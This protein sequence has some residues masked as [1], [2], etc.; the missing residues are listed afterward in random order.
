[1]S[2]PNGGARKRLPQQPS[3]E[4][5]R[6]QAKRR[7]RLDAIQLAEAQHRLAVEYG[8]ASWPKLMAFV[9]AQKTR[10]ADWY[11]DPNDNLPKAANGGDV[12]KVKALLES[13]RFTQA[14]LDTALG[15]VVCGMGN[16]SNTDRWVLA[17]LLIDAG[18]DPD[19]DYG[20]NYGPIIFGPCEGTS[21]EG[22]QYL[23]DKGA[24][25]GF[26][27]IDTKYGKKAP[28][29]HLLG[30]YSRGKN[31]AKHKAIELLLSKGAVIPPEVTPEVFAVHRGDAKL[32]G[33]MIDKDRSLIR[34]TFRDMPYGNIALAGATLLHCAVEFGEI[35]CIDAILSRY[36]NWG[37]LDMNFKAEVIDGIGGQTPIYHAINTNGDRCF[38]VLEYLVQRVGQYID[39]GVKATWRSY[40]QP[41]TEPLTPLE[42]ALKA[43]REMDPKWAHYKPRVKDEIAL[44]VPLDRRA[45]I[46]KA[47]EVGDIDTVRKMLD[48][49]S[50]LLTGELWPGVIMKAR[51]VELVRLLLDRGLSPNDC[52]APRKPLH[53]AA[54][55]M[56][57][58]IIELLVA[59]GA[60]VNF[61][62][63]LG[64][65]PMD[66]IDAYEPR[67]IGD[68]QS[69]RSRNALVKGG[70]KYDIHAAIRM[71][72]MA[73]VKQMLDTDPKAVDV[74]ED[75]W[76]PLAWAARMARIEFVQLLLDRGAVVDGT[77]PQ[78]NT[79]LWFACQSGRDAADRLAVAKL[80]IDHGADVNKRCEEGSMPI[81]YAAWRG[82]KAMVTLLLDHGARHWIADDNG[83]TPADYCRENGVAADKDA[84]LEVLT[85]FRTDDIPFRDAIAAIDAGDVPKLKHLLA[86]HPRLVTDR[87][88]SDS[89]LTRGYFA[90]PALLWFVAE[91]PIRNR[92]LPP[93]IVEVAEAIIDA[94]AKLDDIKYTCGLVASGLV[95]REMKLQT[96][97][98][99]MLVRRGASP[100][101]AL[102]S[103][104][105]ERE[106]EAA[107]AALRLGARHTL[108]SSAALGELDI[109][110]RLLKENPP[111][112]DKLR[113]LMF[114]AQYGQ[115]GAVDTL[116]DTGLNINARLPR[117]F[118]PTAL[119][120][121][122]NFGHRRLVDRMLQRGADPTI[123][124]TQFNGT[125]AGWAWHGGHKELSQYL[126]EIAPLVRA[127]GA[128]RLGDVEELTRLLGEHHDLIHLRLN[129]R[130]LLHILCD[131]PANMPRSSDSARALVAAGIDVNVPL[132][133]DSDHVSR[134][135]AHNATP[136]HWAASSNDATELCQTLID[137]GA[138]INATTADDGTTPLTNAMHFKIDGAAKVLL[139]AG[140]KTSVILAAGLGDLAMVRSF[141]ASDGSLKPA[142]G[143]PPFKHSDER[144]ILSQAINFAAMH[145]HD[146]V[147][148]F[149]AERGAPLSDIDTFVKYNVTPLHRAA[150]NNRVSTAKLLLEL[151]ADPTVKDP[152]FNATPL[153]WAK[154]NG[155][156]DV[157]ALLEGIG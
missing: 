131:W 95:S 34:R 117:V 74:Q 65:V 101:D 24:D 109:L 136:L 154:H 14:D 86:E 133:Q 3:E 42:Y 57:A 79:P 75:G 150:L 88:K 85:A 99:E 106:H 93:N 80:L 116:L 120:E 67:P 11:N 90:N 102:D 129:G 152:T 100:D 135:W 84:I 59:R 2:T 97:L 26:A 15:R 96:P 92:R 54:Y 77:N 27:P 9:D 78:S 91:N 104:I 73:T 72:D 143:D 45:L 46:R 4:N 123:R 145:G 76:Y 5:L 157:A 52:P 141:F 21:L 127:V 139:H 112:K 142:A 12:G 113:A 29:S 32:L 44:L 115:V 1:M 8:F 6:K 98:I 41:Q 114:A 124:D 23:I 60:D 25:V 17:D 39:M 108:V 7:A 81:H 107:Q 87:L 147:I 51:S 38:Y 134:D 37:D 62:N 153:G 71:G 118:E 94:G 63:P 40:G 18:A 49:H 10:S 13:G 61:R 19:G 146:E 89:S 155:C 30:T 130:T 48:E 58:D 110:R 47:C 16:Y 43:E 56:L 20:G 22:I 137:L 126:N 138:D 121:A 36:R 28:L 125:P 103:A 31:E 105:G 151:G 83:K 148:R 132:H 149:L 119:H 128:M 111:E 69:R 55:H 122:A 144:K 33:E 66:L 64:E 53:L 70:A 140:A 156:A 68:E 82:P 35:E 50:E